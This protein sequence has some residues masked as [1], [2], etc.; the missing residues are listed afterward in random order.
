MEVTPAPRVAVVPDGPLARQLERA[1]SDSGAELAADL[2]AA[3]GLIWCSSRPAGLAQILDENPR[4]CWVQLPYAGVEAFSDL[5]GG[6]RTF[7][8]A[9][10]IYGEAVAELALGLLISAFRRL[11]LYAVARTWRP[12]EQSSLAGSAVTIL[13]AGG[14]GRALVRVLNPL[15]A[16][17]TVVSR[18]GAAVKGAR[19][20]PAEA[21]LEAV[22]SADAVVLAL[23]LTAQST[24]LVDGAFLA[25]MRP[26][27]WL[28]NV[29]RGKIVVT[30]DL[31]QALESATIAGAALDVTDPEPLP[32]GHRLFEL[33]NVIVTPHVANTPELGT[34]LLGRLVVKNCRRFVAGEELLGRIDPA[35][36]Y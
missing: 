31:V 9:K 14:I 8:C 18:S 17:V 7:T 10:D 6:D 29:A 33:E 3:Q 21:T 23:P 24:G 5:F 11:H 2:S 34:P 20:L 12:L 4:L 15:G 36:G 28:V 13:G 26:S 32:D 22:A 1:V 16:E 27:A 35:L 25:R 19:S 30:D